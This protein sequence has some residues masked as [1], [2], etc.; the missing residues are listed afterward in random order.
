M[1]IKKL[2]AGKGRAE[3]AILLPIQLK[4]FVLNLLGETTI[5]GFAAGAV[6]DAI[7]SFLPYPFEHP[8]KLSA[9]QAYN[10]SCL[11]L[12][13]PLIQ[14]LVD[15]VQSFCFSSAHGDHVL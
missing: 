9:A 6:A 3:V 15:N 7:V 2:L 8:P 10:L 1:N 4:H 14:C 13:D 11:L 5:R 12:G